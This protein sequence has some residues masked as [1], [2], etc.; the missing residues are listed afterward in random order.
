MEE[1]SNIIDI[2]EPFFIPYFK[3]DSLMFVEKIVK[4]KIYIRETENNLTILSLN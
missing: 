4:F 3:N 2:E 1:T